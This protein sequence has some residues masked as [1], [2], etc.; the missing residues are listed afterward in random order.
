[1]SGSNSHPQLQT[2]VEN[3]G[4]NEVLSSSVYIVGVAT[5][6]STPSWDGSASTSRILYMYMMR[7]TLSVVLLPHLLSQL[8]GRLQTKHVVLG[9][10]K[11]VK[12]KQLIGQR[13]VNNSSVKHAGVDPKGREGREGRGGGRRSRWEE[14]EERRR[15]EYVGCCCRSCYKV[16]IFCDA[17]H[18][19]S[20][21]MF[22]T[23]YQRVYP[24][25]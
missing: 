21:G 19:K 16:D 15:G 8:L 7:L 5:P 2:Q 22:S 20:T 14:R 11:E 23:V 3:Q 24:F 25:T 13:L 4:R 12:E 18:D 1:M 6:S 17:M 10:D 9:R